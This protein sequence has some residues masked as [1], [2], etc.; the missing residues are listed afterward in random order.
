MIHIRHIRNT[1]CRHVS[2]RVSGSGDSELYVGFFSAPL[3]SLS[4]LGYAKGILYHH[5][6]YM[7]TIP[8]AQPEH[9]PSMYRTR[10]IHELHAEHHDSSEFRLYVRSREWLVRCYCTQHHDTTD[11]SEV[12]DHERAET[13]DSQQYL[14]RV[15]VAETRRRDTRAS[16]SA[17]PRALL[18]S[19][20]RVHATQHPAPLSLS[21]KI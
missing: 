2:R 3:V 12:L 13:R 10:Y 18:L 9:T 6:A 7:Y 17:V 8:P 16:P 4:E 5:V 19:P 21:L 14:H 20:V 1:L 11:D 15:R